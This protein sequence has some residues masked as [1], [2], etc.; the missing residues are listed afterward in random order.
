MANIILITTYYPPIKSI[1]SN[2]MIAFSKYLTEMGHNLFVITMETKESKLTKR[3]FRFQDND[4]IKPFDTGIKENFIKHYVKCGLNILQSNIHLYSNSWVDSVTK[5]AGDIIEEENIDVIITSYPRIDTLLVGYKIK[6]LYPDIKWI[7]DMRDAVW[8]PNFGGIVRKKLL[9]ITN[10]CLKECDAVTTVSYV[11]ATQYKHLTDREILCEVVRNGYDFE[12]KDIARTSGGTFNIVYT[13]NFY[14]ALSPR[15]FL[16]AY[17]KCIR[18]YKIEDIR[19]QIIGNASVI[20]MNDDVKRLVQEL[21]H[22]DYMDLITYCAENADLLLVVIPKSR[23]SGV[24]TGKLFDYIGIGRPILGCVPQNDV[25]AELIEQAGN[26]YLAE[27]EDINAIENAIYRAYMDWKNGSARH[28][29]KR[30]QESC[31]RRVEVKKLGR[32]IEKLVI[33]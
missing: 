25:A 3:V 29:N 16:K 31:H 33:R 4:K 32:V 23:E 2:R 26:G 17:E 19:F 20:R 15:N 22:M 14:G 12:A 6:K 7:M 1:A 8:T 11:Q 28:I 21:P 13:G 10:M 5:K 27:N 24:Y 30:V 18:K 9:K